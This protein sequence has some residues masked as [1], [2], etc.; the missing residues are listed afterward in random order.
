MKRNALCLAV[1]LALSSLGG[2]ALAGTCGDSGFNPYTCTADT[3]YDDIFLTGASA[4]DN[5][6]ETTITSW[7]ATGY[8]K[9]TDGT[10]NHRAF[11]GRL[12]NA[13]PVPEAHRGKSIRLIK[14]SAGGSAFGVGPVGRDEF[15][16][17]LDVKNS[18]GTC[19][20]TTSRTCPTVGT[21][22]VSGMKPTFG[23]SDV[24]PALFKGPLNLEYIAAL[25][26]TVTPLT[27]A[28][29]SGMTITPANSLMMGIVA[30]NAVPATTVL[31]RAVYGDLLRKGG[32]ADWSQVDPALT[33]TGGPLAA[34]PGV[35]VCRRYPG[36]GTQSSYN[37][38]FGGFPC[39][40]GSVNGNAY[41]E[42]KE[43]GDSAGY[44]PDGDGLP[45]NAG[46]T[47]ASSAT[48]YT[49]DVASG[50]TVIENSGSGDV[51]NC[52]EKANT[53]GVYTFKN[54]EG[55][56]FK[57]DFGEGGYGAIGVLSLDSLNNQNKCGYTSGVPNTSP[58]AASTGY[59]E[60]TVF[61]WS[62]RTLDGAGTYTDS[63][64]GTSTSPVL[65]SGA[66]GIAP[67][68]AN[69]ISGAYDFAAELTFQY[70]TSKV[71]G[72]TKA[73]V[74]SLVAAI[75]APA[76]NTSVWVAAIPPADSGSNTAKASREGNMC[77]PLKFFY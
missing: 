11:V 27:S 51:R 54:R 43:I 77:S 7:L 44:D 28:E 21:D 64:D 4:P 42:P 40:L 41:A 26:G 32:Y 60:K 48:A 8:V 2:T 68:K 71:T 76:G 65:S 62:F 36:S 39:S 12:K 45:G 22:G 69:L 67:S 55:K 59:N 29:Q 35:V 16:T 49:L 18:A 17:V 10:S 33:A 66:T 53:G 1:G 46:E 58:C 14:R 38:Y 70:K 31:T 63:N 15:L 5:F 30:T 47:G 37:W 34:K 72:T 52:L 75:A 25:G 24:S 6:L 3:G 73:F 13:A 56:W 50:V 19:T 20:G 61:G 57:A 9:I 74:D 23:V